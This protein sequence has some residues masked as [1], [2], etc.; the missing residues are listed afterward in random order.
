MNGLLSQR[1]EE[2]VENIREGILKKGGTKKTEKVYE[3]LG[4]LKEKYPSV[5][6]YYD[7]VVTDQGH[8]IATGINAIIKQVLTLIKRLVYIFCALLSKLRMKLRCGP[9]ITPF[10]K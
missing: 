1:F 5:H 6:K 2:G 3:R 9:S 10:G 7:I 4:R 8:G